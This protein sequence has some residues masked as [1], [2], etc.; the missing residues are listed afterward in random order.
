MGLQLLDELLENPSKNSPPATTPSPSPLRPTPEKHFIPLDVAIP[1]P[2]APSLP[3]TNNI[4][5]ISSNGNE[6]RKPPVPAPRPSKRMDDPNVS[7]LTKLD[8]SDYFC[9][10]EEGEEDEDGDGG[11]PN[12]STPPQDNN[13]MIEVP[14]FPTEDES[15]IYENVIKP[16][17]YHYI[18]TTT[19]GSHTL[20]KTTAATAAPA[21]RRQHK[22]P[23]MGV[24]STLTKK[25]GGYVPSDADILPS[26]YASC[27][28]NGGYAPREVPTDLVDKSPEFK[29]MWVQRPEKL[30]FQDKIRKF[31]LQAGEDEA[32]RDRVKNS[33]AQREIEIKFS[34][35]QKRAMRAAEASQSPLNK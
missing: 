22:F 9:S 21:A 14:N 33:R 5:K 8:I 12:N 6:D 34:D 28:G 29:K 35:A 19:N 4:L 17:D 23:T 26:L 1:E 24:S 11:E 20:P 27:K 7:S 30:T 18:R 31:S 3:L 32:P 16:A 10:G 15:R 25:G 2:P 13:W